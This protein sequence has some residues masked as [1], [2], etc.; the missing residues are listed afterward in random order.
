MRLALTSQYIWYPFVFQ[1]RATGFQANT[2]SQCNEMPRAKRGM[3]YQPEIPCHSSCDQQP[4]AGLVSGGR[5]WMD[6]TRHRLRI[7]TLLL[8]LK[9]IQAA[10]KTPPRPPPLVNLVHRGCAPPCTYL[11]VSPISNHGI[12]FWEVLRLGLCQSTVLY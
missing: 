2:Q 4:G 6:W 9:C 3:S 7:Q 8:V 11:R 12:C 1:G 5:F 10:G